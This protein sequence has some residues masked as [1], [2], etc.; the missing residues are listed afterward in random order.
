MEIRKSLEANFLTCRICNQPFREPKVLLCMHTFCKVCLEHLLEQDKLQAARKRRELEKQR[1]S[2][3]SSNSSSVST[4]KGRWSRA[5]KNSSYGSE[6]ST[7]SYDAY[8]KHR[9]TEDEIQCPVCEK[10]TTL[11]MSGVHGL[12]DDQLAGKLASIVGRIPK[13]PVCDVCDGSVASGCQ[14]NDTDIE[15]SSREVPKATVQTR[16]W[17]DAEDGSTSDIQTTEDEDEQPNAT[18]QRSFGFRSGLLRH[19]R[20][21]RPAQKNKRPTNA[22][23]DEAMMR[24][25]IG[26]CSANQVEPH[27]AI[28]AC[29]E[30]GKRLCDYCHRNHK[31]IAVTAD[32]VIVSLEQLESMYC[33]RHPR[34]L[35]RF[36]CVTCGELICLVCTFESSLSG[37]NSDV[38]LD[39]PTPPSP[40]GH[41]EHEV[42]SIRQGICALE[43]CIN[44]AAFDCKQKAERLELLLLGIRSCEGHV[45]SLKDAI[46]A[47]ADEMTQEI[48]NRK[49]ALLRELDADVG[50]PLNSLVNQRETIV[51][52]VTSWEELQGED[53]YLDALVGLHPVQAVTEASLIRDRFVSCLEVLNASIPRT[54]NWSKLVVEVDSLAQ[55]FNKLNG[56]ADDMYGSEAAAGKKEEGDDDEDA[57][58]PLENGDAKVSKR[59]RF[60]PPAEFAGVIPASY[61]AHWTRRLGKFIKGAGVQLG[62]RATPGQLAAE[63]ALRQEKIVSRAIQASPTDVHGKPLPPEKDS[64][65]HRAVQVD[66]LQANKTDLAVQT[67]PCPVVATAQRGKQDAGTQYQSVD[68]NVPVSFFRSS[69]QIVVQQ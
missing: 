38:N 28:A 58:V 18:S 34:E 43:R 65:R 56:L 37:A 19:T 6:S 64:R 8:G 33:T 11:P 17:T 41:S 30:C 24:P 59:V 10:K 27:R 49:A 26:T 35:R 13:Y 52:S 16:P 45:K 22:S 9:F 61:T 69:R 62:R 60:K 14:A 5:F 15:L 40:C 39:N 48:A 46:E 36:F 47:A 51:N 2:G 68:I 3:Y 29:L 44:K 20:R 57:V 66:L 42:V 50:V 55:N 1:S 7:T 21:H 67:E 32:H 23:D 4:Y 63:T 54:D 25:T 31:R 12:P 53:G